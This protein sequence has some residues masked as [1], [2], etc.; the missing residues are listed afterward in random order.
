MDVLTPLFNAKFISLMSSTIENDYSHIKVSKL[1]KYGRFVL[2]R[3]ISIKKRNLISRVSRFYRFLNPP[4]FSIAVL[5]TDGAGKTTIID[6]ISEPLNEA[7]HNALFYEHM[8]PNLIPNIAQ[9]FGRE[10]QSGTV[11]D[12]HEAETSGFIG[13]LLRLLY[14]S[15]DYIFGY[16]FKVYPVTVKKSSIWIFDRYY[17]DYLI[18]P[19]RARMNLPNWVIKIMRFF[20][21]EPDLI[22]CLGASPEVIHTRKPELPLNEVITQVNK[23][24]IFCENES[25]ATWIDTGIPLDDTINQ[26]IEVI[27]NKMASRYT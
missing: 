11:V 6:A 27:A 9:L 3:D 8:R 21:P 20:I 22:L 18:D 23:L 24:K 15:T 26:A 14:Y 1:G 4:G 10:K 5:G 19:K 12:P 13:S 25:K 16:W 17:Y 7:V 2:T